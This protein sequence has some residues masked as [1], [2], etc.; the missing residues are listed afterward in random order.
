MAEKVEKNKQTNF[1]MGELEYKK[2]IWALALPSI[3]S[4]LVLSLYVTIDRLMI[5]HFVGGEGLAAIQYF[6]PALSF[7]IAM[8]IAIGT[9]TKT[10]I[11][12]LYGRKDY[13][14]S[15]EALASGFLITLFLSLITTFFIFFL[16]PLIPLWM[17]AESNIA[18]LSSIYFFMFTFGIIPQSFV[19][20][21]E[22]V[23]TAK[24]YTKIIL[25]FTIISQVLNL[26]FDYLLMG[27]FDWGISG[28]AFATVFSMY[29]SFICY[30]SYII[31]IKKEFLINPFKYKFISKTTKKIIKLGI[32]SSIAQVIIAVK[33]I[34]V[35]VLLSSFKEPSLII[36]YSATMAILNTFFI[37]FFGLSSA[38]IP[39]MGYNYGS[40]NFQRVK[41]VWKYKIKISFM[42]FIF[43]IGLLWLF[44]RFFLGI[45]NASTYK[46]SEWLPRI[47]TMGLWVFPLIMAYGFLFQAI[48]NVKE[49]LYLNMI[50]NVFVF[51]PTILVF[52]M[53]N[54]PLLLLFAF[55]FSDFLGII[56]VFLF[57][58]TKFWKKLDKDF[59]ESWN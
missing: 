40:K 23:F 9:G 13:E 38:T 46:Y 14:K 56:L 44:P 19:Y 11:S 15:K 4:F 6:Q 2:A 3:S 42:Y 7:L 27:V 51:V 16:G 12:I 57:A 18:N 49:S 29:V 41:K 55:P 21:S 17:G 31:F 50:R 8:L 35:T 52:R 26:S 28:A 32:P 53:F 36:V 22:S 47:I 39:M 59:Q 25:V 58:K 54:N 1:I 5:S 24:G 33:F 10:L 20:F 43:F 34:L 30:I 48:G 45:F 37:P